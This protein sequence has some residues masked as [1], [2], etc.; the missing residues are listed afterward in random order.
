MPRPEPITFISEIYRYETSTPLLYISQ[1]IKRGETAVSG[2]LKRIDA[3]HTSLSQEIGLG[4]NLYVR[5]ISCSMQHL[6][7]SVGNIM[8]S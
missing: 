4:M 5:R 1:P 8:D 3:L 6:R 7:H 2:E